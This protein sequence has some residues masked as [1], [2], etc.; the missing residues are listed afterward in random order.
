MHPY[1]DC[2]PAIPVK[3]H[4]TMPQAES[5]GPDEAPV[6]PKPRDAA[7]GHLGAKES[8]PDHRSPLPSSAD[9]EPDRRFV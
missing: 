3:P 5:L 1:P 9:Q 2:A 6:P 7:K 4:A 8:Y